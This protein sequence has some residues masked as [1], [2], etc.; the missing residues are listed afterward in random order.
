MKPA[1]PGIAI[2]T[3]KAAAVPIALCI[4]KPYIFKNGMLI[5][6]P[7]T[8]INTDKNPINEPHERPNMFLG[9]SGE[10]SQVSLQ[11][12]NWNATIIRMIE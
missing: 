11:K 4:W 2:I 9:N 1:A 8:P 3:P 12:K 5:E 10:I 7:P 6:P